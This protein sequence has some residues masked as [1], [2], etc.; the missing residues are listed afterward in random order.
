MRISLVLSVAS[1]AFVLCACSSTRALSPGGLSL[2]TEVKGTWKDPK[3]TA[4]P[5]KTIFV[6]SLM[7]IEPGGR[8]TVENAIVAQL[9]TA[10]VNGVASH[11]IM[12]NDAERPGPS[13]EEAIKASGAEGVLLVE[14]RAV[15][16]Y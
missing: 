13:L 7:K 1:V 11:T 3:Y 5:L 12:S 14:V 4:G 8:N 15:G 9:K 10:G 6:I 2:K 16:A